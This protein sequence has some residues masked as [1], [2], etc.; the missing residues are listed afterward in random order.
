[1]SAGDRTLHGALMPR[2]VASQRHPGRAP[3]AGKHRA[4]ADQSQFAARKPAPQPLEDAGSLETV[5]SVGGV[6]PVDGGS[7]DAVVGDDP[8]LAVVEVASDGGINGPPS[9]GAVVGAAPRVGG[10][11]GALDGSD[12]DAVPPVVGT[13]DDVMSHPC[14]VTAS[15]A[16]AVPAVSQ[17]HRP[18][19]STRTPRPS[20]TARGVPELRP[21]ESPPSCAMRAPTR[22]IAACRS[23]VSGPG[24]VLTTGTSAEVGQLGYC[25]KWAEATRKCKR[26]QSSVDFAHPRLPFF[27]PGRASPGVGDRG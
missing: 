21:P 22:G 5:L 26:R 6:V 15:H 2:L 16:C 1:M 24:D 20:R 18:T 25:G 4:D 10:C 9:A 14:P 11:P 3:R 23:R 27:F 17:R 7:V 12:G 8:P 19:T 13:D